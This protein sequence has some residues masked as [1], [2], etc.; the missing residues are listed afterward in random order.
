MN[1]VK[2]GDRAGDSDD[3]DATCMLMLSFWLLSLH[4]VVVHSYVVRENLVLFMAV[5]ARW[6][7]SGL[8]SSLD[9]HL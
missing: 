5:F 3:E 7:V 6:I 2:L 4:F 9:G 1:R 8:A